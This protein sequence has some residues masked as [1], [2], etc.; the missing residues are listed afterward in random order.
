MGAGPPFVVVW[1]V[2]PRPLQA[3]G[4]SR[5][6]VHTTAFTTL[7][8][9]FQIP[10][11]YILTAVLR[12]SHQSFASVANLSAPVSIGRQASMHLTA[13][14]SGYRVCTLHIF[15]L[16][17]KKLIDM[18]VPCNPLRWCGE[19]RRALAHIIFMHLC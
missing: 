10:D 7:W 15:P 17:Q 4:G 3:S 8:L 18:C 16:A 12:N 5:G 13:L 1:R 9:L 11:P 2:S 19:K 6:G 14:H